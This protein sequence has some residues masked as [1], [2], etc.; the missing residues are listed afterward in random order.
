[1]SGDNCGTDAESW[2]ALAMWTFLAGA[3]VAEQ[4]V[5]IDIAGDQKMV[6]LMC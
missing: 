1:M 5:V 2:A 6:P 4:V 3:G